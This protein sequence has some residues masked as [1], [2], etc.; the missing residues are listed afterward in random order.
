M[1]NTFSNNKV[2]FGILSVLVLLSLFLLVQTIG[3]AKKIKYIGGDPG[4]RNVISVVGKGE[5]LTNPD[6]IRFSYTVT[7]ESM[8]ISEAQKSVE[9]RIKDTLEALKKRGV[10]EEDI[11]TT[12]YNVYPRYEYPVTPKMGGY[13][14]EG[15]RVLAGYVVTQTAEV[16][17]R[18]M[19]TIGGILGD[20]GEIG[21]DEISSLSF[22][23]DKDE[24]LQREARKDAIRDAKERARELADDLGVRLVEVTGY[25]ESGNYPIYYKYDRVMAQEG[26]PGMGGSD[27]SIPAGQNKITSEVTITYEIR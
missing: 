27:L 21:A 18:K 6:L 12:T 17:V 3:G 1:Y 16:K 15:K 20:L 26:S 25:Y 5:R 14:S 10:A 2:Q 8:E 22:E 4:N 19:D 13:Y 11:K 7:E 24:E 23:V 9:K